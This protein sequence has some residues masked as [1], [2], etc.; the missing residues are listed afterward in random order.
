MNPLETCSREFSD[1]RSNGAATLET[2]ICGP[3]A[4]LLN[5]GPGLRG[6]FIRVGTAHHI[7]SYLTVIRSYSKHSYDHQGALNDNSE[8]KNLTKDLKN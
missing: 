7:K 8:D 2:S 6:H 3:L 4:G 5:F 1:I